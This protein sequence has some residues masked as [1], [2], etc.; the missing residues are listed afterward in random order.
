MGMSLSCPAL[1]SASSTRSRFA[2][3]ASPPSRPRFLDGQGSSPCAG[4]RQATQ[5]S[6]LTLQRQTLDAAI[7]M[8]RMQVAALQQRQQ[9]SRTELEGELEHTRAE[10]RA[11]N[12]RRVL[13]LAHELGRWANEAG[14]VQ[15]DRHGRVSAHF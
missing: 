12:L 14:V 15:A 10:I 1:V 9:Q 13:A 5:L 6:E 11:A 3:S 7:Y 4:P 2:S 8:K